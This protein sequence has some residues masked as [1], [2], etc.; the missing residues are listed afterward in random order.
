[1]SHA[2]SPP[3]LGPA[4][5]LRWPRA[6]D[7][8]DPER[9]FSSVEMARR[10]NVLFMFGQP[11]SSP[12]FSVHANVMRFLDPDRVR[13]HVVY[14]RLAEEESYR[15]AK[16]SLLD[17][18][19]QQASLDLRAVD[20]GPVGGPSRRAMLSTAARSAPSAAASL[21]GL[22]RYM[23]RSGID[24]VHCEEGTRN[25]F[26]PWVL[27][28]LGGARCVLH[29]HSRY[30]SWMTP[31][32]RVAVQRSDA[33]IAVSGWTGRGIHDGGGVPRER[34]FP[35]LNGVDPQEWDPARANGAAV[36]RE[37]A[38]GEPDP[39]V[40]MVAQLVAWKRQLKLI[41]A[42][43]RVLDS[44]PGARLL[45][46]GLEHNPPSGP[47]AISYTEE[48][49]RLVAELGLDDHVIL[50]GR[51]G[52]VREILAAAD[53]FAHPSVDDPCPLAEIEAMA[54]A[55]PVVAVHAAGSAELVLDGETGLLSP[56]DDVDALA[57]NLLAL[58]EDPDRRRRLGDA[59]RRRVVDYLNLRRVAV[60]I[61][62]V[63]RSTT[64]GAPT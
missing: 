21:A 31:P 32:S 10:L 18:I 17:I 59:G 42:F 51:R 5:S 29:F 54:M 33:I 49:R 14:N 53:V 38:I 47:G 41:A 58:V 20:L 8:P 4:G 13:V 37:F 44:H 36:R 3:G 63:Y 57:A 56:P 40:V 23:R 1:M 26:L 55:R 7:Q 27:S 9:D 39:L 64:Q 11:T 28:R 6:L 45:L 12:A 24:V 22:V 25:G 50:A 15:A 62:A 30:G 52:D 16:T 2:L 34:I 19:P 61:E 35:V 60:E 46:A 43:R 48:V